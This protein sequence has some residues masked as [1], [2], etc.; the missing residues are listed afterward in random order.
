MAP[1]LFL[2]RN[3][4]PRTTTH[5]LAA[6]PLLEAF[7]RAWFIPNLSQGSSDLTVSVWAS[8]LQLVV[9]PLLLLLAGCLGASQKQLPFWE[10]HEDHCQNLPWP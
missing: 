7:Y 8:S 3:T 4:P 6:F 2:I 10:E 1:H 9:L 5:L